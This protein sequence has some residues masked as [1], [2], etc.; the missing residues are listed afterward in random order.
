M[1]EL[2]GLGFVVEISPNAAATGAVINQIP[3]A[4]TYLNYGSTVTIEI[5]EEVE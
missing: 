2:E 5:Q 1:I 4:D 3:K